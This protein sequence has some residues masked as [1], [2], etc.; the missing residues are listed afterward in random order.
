MRREKWIADNS[1]K[2]SVVKLENA[3]EDT[4]YLYSMIHLFRY[5]KSSPFYYVWSKD[6]M[7]CMT[8]DRLIAENSFESCIKVIEMTRRL[9]WGEESAKHR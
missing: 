8:P 1:G 7:V 3:Y 2:F 6:K 4:T 9:L 5:G